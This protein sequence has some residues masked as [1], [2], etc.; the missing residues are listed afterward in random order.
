[1]F[2]VGN[3]AIPSYG[4]MLYLGSVFGIVA[5][6][7]FASGLGMSAQRFALAAVV[8]LVPA[9]V[10]ARLWYVLQNLAYFRE[11]LE[12]VFRPMDVGAA[13]DGGLVLSVLVSVPLLWAAQLPFWAFWDAAAVT[14][15][16]GSIV[17]RVGCLM[18]GCCAGRTTEAWVGVL[19]PNHRGE[20]KR[21][22]PT[23]VFEAAL[24]GLMLAGLLSGQR[25]HPQTGLLFGGCLVVYAIMRPVIALTRETD[26]FARMMRISVGVSTVFLAFG[27][28]FIASAHTASSQPNFINHNRID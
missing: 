27:V 8:L 7:A 24:S 1:L 11:R 21:R 9:F 6:A 16:V 20:W 25:L 22:Y 5:G 18:N 19:L 12:R 28:L 3:L 15:F 10:G 13:Q 23:P 4:A 17:T 26:N 14:M 2:H